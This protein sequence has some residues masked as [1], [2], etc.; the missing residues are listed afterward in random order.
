H[1][2]KYVVRH[3]DGTIEQEMGPLEKD[4]EGPTYTLHEVRQRARGLQGT[5]YEGQMKGILADMQVYPH[6]AFKDV[7]LANGSPGLAEILGGKFTYSRPQTAQMFNTRFDADDFIAARA[8]RS[9]AEAREDHPYTTVPVLK[10][11][12][13]GEQYFDR[14]G[15]YLIYNTKTDEYL[16]PDGSWIKGQKGKD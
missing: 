7:M 14:K 4:Y 16:H 3:P 11:D 15:N 5:Q 1:R 8:R 2:G 9:M 6:Y 13:D 10:V 12:D